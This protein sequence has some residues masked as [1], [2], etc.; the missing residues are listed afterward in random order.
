LDNILIGELLKVREHVRPGVA[1]IAET[2][3]FLPSK[4]LVRLS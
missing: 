4:R 1:D 2:A 3:Q